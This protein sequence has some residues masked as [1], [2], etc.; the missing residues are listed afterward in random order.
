[1]SFDFTL[2]DFQRHGAAEADAP[3][4]QEWNALVANANTPIVVWPWHDY[5]PTQ[6]SSD[7]VA[8]PYTVEMYTHFIERAYLAGD[9]F[10][11]AADLAARIQSFV[12]SGVT[13]TVNGNVITVSVAS[14]HA[15][16][17]ALDVAGQ[18]SQVIQNVANWYAY[19]SDSLFLPETGGSYHDHPGR[20]RGRCHAHHRP[21]DA[22]RPALGHRRRPQPQL[23]HGR[24]G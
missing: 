4:A 19:D 8:S 13:S 18:G 22:G 15:G 24:R 3:W 9:E 2:V 1:M 12:Q 16:D 23:L 20:R 10:V 6:W 17:F 7:G 21:A 14:A 11:T 5:G